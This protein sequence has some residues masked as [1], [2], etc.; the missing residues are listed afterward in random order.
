MHTS[1]QQQHAQPYPAGILW[2]FD[3]TD[4]QEDEL[5]DVHDGILDAPTD[6]EGPGSVDDVNRDPNAPPHGRPETLEDL[7]RKAGFR[8]IID[9]TPTDYSPSRS[10]RKH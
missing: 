5:Q 9:P 2:R 7:E 10:P 3:G 6:D 4:G 8:P 1:V